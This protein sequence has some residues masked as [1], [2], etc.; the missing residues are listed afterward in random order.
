MYCKFYG[1][2]RLPF[3]ATSNSN[4]FFESSSH[5]EAYAAIEYGITERKGII[6]I[7]GEVGTGK[8]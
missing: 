4:F 6:L 1:F 7:T 3:S 5:R 8:T 2:K